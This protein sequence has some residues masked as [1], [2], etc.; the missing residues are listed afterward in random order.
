[1]SLD[2]EPDAT[3]A[4]SDVDDD[5]PPIRCPQCAWRP[6]AQDRWSCLCGHCWNTFDTGG[7]CPACGE[8]W[9]HT[10]CLSCHRWSPHHDWYA[11][12]DG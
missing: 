6:R 9:D 12:P 1:M 8:R 5:E 7:R 4:E 10:Q 2:R 3:P 11:R